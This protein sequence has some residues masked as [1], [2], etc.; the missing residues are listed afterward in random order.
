MYY[1]L[2]IVNSKEFEHILKKL[3]LIVK[4]V[5]QTDPKKI[6]NL[7]YFCQHFAKHAEKVHLQVN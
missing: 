2:T 4:D 3:N 6:I 1:I 5:E 7:V